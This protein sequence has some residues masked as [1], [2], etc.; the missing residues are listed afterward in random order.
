[1]KITK[2]IQRL[3][4]SSLILSFL[5]LSSCVGNAHKIRMER[6]YKYLESNRDEEAIADFT[7]VFDKSSDKELVYESAKNLAEIYTR[8][9]DYK[10]ALRFLE[11]MIAN[12][13]NFPASLDALKKKAQIQHKDLSLFEEAIITYSRI[14]S[15]SD[16]KESEQN[17]MR[18]NLSNCYFSINKFEQAR[19]ELAPLLDWKQPKDVRLEAQRLEATIF[20]AEGQFEKAINAYNLILASAEDEKQKRDALINLSLC[21]E[22]K[23]DYLGALEALNKVPKKDEV[24]D[25]KIK[26]LQRMSVFQGRRLRK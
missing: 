20:Q 17:E 4:I 5:I 16:L 13:D 23:E 21:Y 11:V 1:M 6:G 22:Q 2:M 9:K 18:L 14:L 3:W 25:A 19:G 10:T 12:A 8:K 24:L 15:Y 7:Y 26:Q